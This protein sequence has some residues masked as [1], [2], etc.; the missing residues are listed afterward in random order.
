MSA[1]EA[2]LSHLHGINA[3]N[4]EQRNAPEGSTQEIIAESVRH[5]RAA[6]GNALAKL[7]RADLV[8]RIVRRVEGRGRRRW[9]YRLTPRGVL[10]ARCGMRRVN[11]CP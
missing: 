9:T 11:G 7:M 1:V 4:G 10:C 2:V 6:V 3:G 5:S 8:E